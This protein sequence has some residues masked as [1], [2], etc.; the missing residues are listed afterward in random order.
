MQFAVPC[1]SDLDPAAEYALAQTYFLPHRDGAVQAVPGPAP[2][3][4]RRSAAGPGAGGAQDSNAAGAQPGF[5]K[6]AG[7]GPQ[8]NRPRLGCEA[9]AAL[10]AGQPLLALRL[11][12]LSATL[13]LGIE[14]DT[15]AAALEAAPGLA[16]A[17]SGQIRDELNCALTGARPSALEPL[18]AA[19]A[20]EPFGLCPPQRPLGPLDTT[21]PGL[22]C[23]W[24]AF[25]QLAGVPRAAAAAHMQFGQSFL[26]DLA[27]LDGLFEAGPPRDRLALK[28]Q[29]ADG[30]PL[31]YAVL[32]AA[33]TAVD[34]AFAPA[35]GLYAELVKSGEPCRPDQ[36]AITEAGLLAEGVRAK[37]LRETHRQLLRAVLRQPGLNTY[38]TL[39]GLARQ[40]Q[41]FL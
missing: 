23:R 34:P 3:A 35:A 9:P 15:R 40:L 11:F 28:L 10:F 38:P 31:G 37:R 30:L 17:A 4:A 41:R 39:A 8:A 29:L 6:A 20:L 25:L 26:A 36:L 27:R 14:P 7:P 33:F 12:R 19:G 24:W 1:A 21:P 22:L 18:L 32:A 2:D 13:G 5:A 16:A